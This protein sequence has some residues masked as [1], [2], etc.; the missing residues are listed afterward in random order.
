[1]VR[2]I[3]RFYSSLTSLT[4]YN[5]NWEHSLNLYVL[6]VDNYAAFINCMPVGRASDYDGPD[7]KLL[8]LV[9][10]GRCFLSVD[11]PTGVQLVFFLLHRVSVSYSAS[12][13]SIVGQLTESVVSSFLIHP[14]GYH[15]LFVCPR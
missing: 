14:D 2:V 5:E 8:I 9:R 13:I 3:I 12:G 7:I 4:Q 15:D 6:M 1:M 10:W 11:W